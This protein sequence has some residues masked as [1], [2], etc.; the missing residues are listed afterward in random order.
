MHACIATV[1]YAKY[2]CIATIPC[3]MYASIATVLCA[4]YACIATVPCAKYVRIATVPEN[5]NSTTQKMVIFNFKWYIEAFSSAVCQQG[6]RLETENTNQTCEL[7]ECTF[8]TQLRK[9]HNNY[10]VT[11]KTTSRIYR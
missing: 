5:G 8:I 9:G 4:I 1:P 3:A 6:F 10:D 7:F 11:T 2:A